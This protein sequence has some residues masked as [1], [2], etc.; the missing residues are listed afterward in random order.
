MPILCLDAMGRTSD[1]RERLLEAAIDLIWASSF[2]SVSVDQICETAG[3]KKGSFYHF[4]ASKI[5]LAL[6]AYDTAWE[7]KRA[8]LDAIF[9]AQRPPLERLERWCKEMIAVQ[10]D[11]AKKTGHVCGCPVSSVA[12]E[13]GTQDE[14]LRLKSAQLL[15]QTRTYVVSALRDA[16]ARGDVD[17]PDPET[18]SRNI[19]SFVLG[20]MLRAKV[21]NDAGVMADLYR[22]ILGLIG[23]K[24]APQKA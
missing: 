18:C 16:H 6:A 24:L 22:E 7:Q 13:M 17:V 5:D 19:Q 10:I 23:A 12:A 9:S 4:F 20:S 1:T 8:T 3:V 2:G 21:A 11:R 14:R 15:E